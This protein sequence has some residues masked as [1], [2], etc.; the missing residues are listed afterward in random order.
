MYN[1]CFIKKLY[2]QLLQLVCKKIV[3]N[4]TVSRQ[5]F[6]LLFNIKYF[7]CVFVHSKKCEFLMAY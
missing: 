6:T 4:K 5:Q 2:I 1:Y 7:N 3:L